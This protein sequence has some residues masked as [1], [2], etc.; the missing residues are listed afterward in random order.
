MVSLWL[1][2]DNCVY[3][4]TFFTYSF[5]FALYI[6]KNSN[7]ASLNKSVE[8]VQGLTTS[9]N[10]VYL[11]FKGGRD[12]GRKIGTSRIRGTCGPGCGK[13]CLFGSEEPNRRE[14]L[15]TGLSAGMER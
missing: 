3:L 7:C 1:N 15:L 9:L 8:V 2:L 6:V 11:G 4:I 10:L 13:A 12:Y 5:F 14:I